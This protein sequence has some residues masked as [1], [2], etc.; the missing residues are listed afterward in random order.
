VGWGD[1]WEG[2]NR[3]REAGA[4]FI[5]R[6]SLARPAAARTWT[7]GAVPQW[8][9]PARSQATTYAAR[10]GVTGARTPLLCS[11]ASRLD[12]HHVSPCPVAVH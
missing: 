9:A 4:I 11:A 10:I 6:R 3:S 12:V 8:L 2:R 1:W 5:A 7:S